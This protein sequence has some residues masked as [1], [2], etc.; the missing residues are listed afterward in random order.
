ML[1]LSL[2]VWSS[3]RYGRGMGA[4]DPK[5][6]VIAGYDRCAPAYA[7][8]R[9]ADASP[10]LALLGEQLPP[11][12]RV[13]DVGCGAGVPVTAA[14]ARTAS[15]VGVDISAQQIALAR[16]NVPAAEFIHG[17]IMTQ[18]F[19]DASFD[20]VVAF[21]V[22]FHLPRDE[23]LELLRKL[24]RWLRPGG[25]LLATLPRTAHPGYTEPDFFGVTMYWSHHATRWYAERLQEM[26][27][28]VLHLGV[29]G[30]GV[31]EVAGLRPER[32]P[33]VLARRS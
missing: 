4:E 33:V 20:A 8:A 24:H 6:I 29:V 5:Q 25:H 23:Q 1:G 3:T 2:R 7:A 12:A 13:L 16:S 26:E 21:Y 17:D 10:E 15:V 9:V 32:H 31:R 19:D 27:F 28:E 18:C 11:N 30:H 22:I 14:L